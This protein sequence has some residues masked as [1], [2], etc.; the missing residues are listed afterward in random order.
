MVATELLEITGRIYEEDPENDPYDGNDVST[1]GYT[2]AAIMELASGFNTPVHVMWGRSKIDSCVPTRS[3]TKRWFSVYGVIIYSQLAM[4][5]PSRPLLNRRLSFQTA[6]PTNIDPICKHTSKA[7]HFV[8]W[9]LH[10]QMQPGH[11]YNRHIMGTGASLHTQGFAPTV[12]LS[13]LGQVRALT[14]ND[15]VVHAKTKQHFLESF[16]KALLVICSSSSE[17]EPPFIR[18]VTAM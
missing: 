16:S 15:C 8:E 11:F 17:V 13:G 18:E 4:W 5:L 6:C 1:L 7:V 12:R 10:T 2:A 3:N 9:E 14:W